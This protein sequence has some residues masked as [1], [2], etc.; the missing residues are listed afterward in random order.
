MSRPTGRTR[1][2]TKG[3]A[4]GGKETKYEKDKVYVVEVLEQGGEDDEDEWKGL[5]GEKGFGKGAWRGEPTR[6]L[7][8]DEGHAKRRVDELPEAVK[9]VLEHEANQGGPFAYELVQCQLTLFYDYWPMNERCT[10]LGL[11]LWLTT[12]P[13]QSFLAG[14]SPQHH[15]GATE[16]RIWVTSTPTQFCAPVAR[17]QQP[18]LQAEPA[19]ARLQSLRRRT[20]TLPLQIQDSGKTSTC[21]GRFN[22]HCT[23]SVSSCGN[24]QFLVQ[25]CV[26]RKCNQYIFLRHRIG[27]KKYMVLE[28]LLPEGIIIPAGFETVGHIAHLNL[29]DEHLPYKTLIAQVI[30]EY[31]MVVLDKNKPKIQTVVNKIDAI[32]NDYRTMQLE[33]LAGHDSLVTTVIESGLRF[34]VDLATVYW[35]SRLSTER[36][37]L[38]NNIFQNSDVVCDVFSGVGP[39]AISAAKKVKYVY[40]NDLNPAAVEY[41]EQNI[42]LNKLERKI[43]VIPN[44]TSKYV[45]V[46]PV[47]LFCLSRS[48]SEM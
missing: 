7:L 33:I 21:S 36:Q 32:Q 17:P 47:H 19:H 23:G 29:R 42:V 2:E 40:A 43:E 13:Q 48:M 12:H 41:L 3:R 38:V 37:R 16:P 44:F 11:L 4:A 5:V 15:T 14:P 9:V 26:H 28:A 25:R 27:K 22:C 46:A 8:L 18:P 6:L 30:S 1:R 35:N 20:V 45:R 24:V 10:D 31:I 34:Q 39:I